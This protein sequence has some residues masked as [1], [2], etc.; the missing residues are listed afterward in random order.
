VNKVGDDDASEMIL[1]GFNKFQID[2]TFQTKVPG[3]SGQ[4]LIFSYPNGDNSIV[5]IPGANGEWKYSYEQFVHKYQVPLNA[6]AILMQREINEEVNSFIAEYTKGKDTVTMYDFGGKD[7]EF[8]LETL[9]NYT[10]LSPNCTELKRIL[11]QIGN[12]IGTHAEF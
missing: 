2:S 11:N 12:Q 8:D 1:N 4:A 6:Q 3:P 9:K 5:I 7:S 10:Y